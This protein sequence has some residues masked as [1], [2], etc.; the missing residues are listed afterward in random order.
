MVD[1]LLTFP[2]DRTRKDDP[3]NIFMKKRKKKIQI[4]FLLKL[5]KNYIFHILF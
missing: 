1:H 4:I 3:R 5:P 2:K